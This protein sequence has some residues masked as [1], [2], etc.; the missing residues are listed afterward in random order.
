MPNDRQEVHGRMHNYQLQEKSTHPQINVV[1]LVLKIHHAVFCWLKCSHTDAY[2]YLNISSR[3]YFIFR[4]I[5]RE[6][7]YNM[8]ERTKAFE[9]CILYLTYLL[10]ENR[11]I[12][13]SEISYRIL[14]NNCDMFWLT[15][16]CSLVCNISKLRK[17]RK[18]KTSNT[19]P[20]R[21]MRTVPLDF[22]DTMVKMTM[23]YVQYVTV[24]GVQS[25]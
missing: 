13:Y 15:F 21:F 23:P 4:Y 3:R 11:A 10:T 8:W 19:S 9:I 2:F 20:I 6:L 24:H 7:N 16:H 14:Q 17:N 1:V 5:L 22:S 12:L 25:W 18:R